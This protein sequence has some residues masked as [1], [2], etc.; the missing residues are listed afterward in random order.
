MTKLK[1]GNVL[2]ILLILV[3]AST[4]IVLVLGQVE[5]NANEY[6]S[7]IKFSYSRLYLTYDYSCDQNVYGLYL[8]LTNAGSK[9]VSNFSVSVSNALCVG[10]VP[11]LPSTF[12]P[13][14]SLKFYVYSADQNGT[15]SI[16]G[17][18]TNLLVSF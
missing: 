4:V 14:Q 12:Y 11:P 6:Q 7:Y 18:N 10:S 15:V 16:M 1:L 5:Q 9:M 3:V 2:T 8:T 17:N 13:S